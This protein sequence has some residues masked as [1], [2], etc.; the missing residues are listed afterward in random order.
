MRTQINGNLLF[1]YFID[2]RGKE[3][4]GDVATTRRRVRKIENPDL[5]IL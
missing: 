3:L 1:Q 5:E 4:A 2:S